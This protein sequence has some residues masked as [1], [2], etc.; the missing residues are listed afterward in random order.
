MAPDSRFIVGNGSRFIL[1]GGEILST[2]N[3]LWKG[4]KVEGNGFFLI[5]PD[6]L[7]EGNYFYAYADNTIF[8]SPKN[9][10]ENSIDD[11]NVE[12]PATLKKDYVIFP[13]PTGDFINILTKNHISQVQLYDIYGNKYPSN[14]SNNILD[15]RNLPIGNYIL[16]IISQFDT[17]SITFSKK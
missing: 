7:I 13:N 11:G 9:S 14:Y 10:I 8:P 16:I 4:I 3:S 1:E 2:S 5:N 6:T 15:V 17:K 12:K